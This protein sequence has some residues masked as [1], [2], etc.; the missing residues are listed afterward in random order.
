[1]LQ[2]SNSFESEE[3]QKEEKATREKIPEEERRDTT[4]KKESDQ[5]QTDVVRDV[6]G[7]VEDI[8]EGPIK[9]DV[10]RLVSWQK[11]PQTPLYCETCLILDN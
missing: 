4:W 5:E 11:T 10:A 2:R 9:E 7:D 1:M 6:V 3:E 8:N